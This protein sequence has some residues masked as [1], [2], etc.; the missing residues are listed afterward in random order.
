MISGCV[1]GMSDGTALFVKF[2]LA[3]R[4][5]HRLLFWQEVEAF[6]AQFVSDSFTDAIQLGPFTPLPAAAATMPGTT[7]QA[8]IHSAATCL[9]ATAR[10]KTTDGNY[11]TDDLKD[12]MT[13]VTL[14]HENKSDA[15]DSALDQIGPSRTA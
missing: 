8:D 13:R 9:P 11:T 15:N 5:E 14:G 2:L 7:A 6:R 4:G 10:E 1:Q 12:H 3:E